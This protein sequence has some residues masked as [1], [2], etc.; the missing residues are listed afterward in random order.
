MGNFDKV[1]VVMDGTTIMY[2]H[3]GTADKEPG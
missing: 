3:K 2:R 1:T